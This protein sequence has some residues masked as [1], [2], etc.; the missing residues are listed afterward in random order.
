MLIGYSTKQ[1]EHNKVDT[2]ITFHGQLIWIERTGD[3]ARD[4]RL[5]EAFRKW[6]QP[7]GSRHP[8]RCN[9]EGCDDR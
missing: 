8:C 2:G 3:A 9:K 4:A 7:M 5:L 1:I 6:V